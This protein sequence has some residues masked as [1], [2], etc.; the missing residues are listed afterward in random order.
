ML[1]V[2]IYPDEVLLFV[3]S[4]GRVVFFDIL[5]P[6][7]HDL[8]EVIHRALRHAIARVHLSGGSV[9]DDLG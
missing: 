8:V 5:T 1:H 6:L 3:P 9:G 7:E 4:T 2:I